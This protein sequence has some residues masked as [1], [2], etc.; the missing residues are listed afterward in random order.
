MFVR[1]VLQQYRKLVTAEARNEIAGTQL[2]RK[3]SRHISQQLV[4][5]CMS[6]CVID[7]FEIVEINDE[8]CK[9]LMRGFGS[10]KHVRESLIK[11]RPVG[12]ACQ[13]IAERE[14]LDFFPLPSV[15]CDVAHTD[16]GGS[17]RK[18]FDTAIDRLPLFDD[19]SSR[20]ATGVENL[21]RDGCLGRGKGLTA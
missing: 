12:E 5:G 21:R 16:K 1:Y 10:S 6:E 19:H 20:H 9:T 18:F 14:L 3:P 15:L 2:G 11:P 8:K 4:S 7:V 13:R 17:L